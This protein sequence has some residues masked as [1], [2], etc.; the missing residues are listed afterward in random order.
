MNLF[1][2]PKIKGDFGYF[3]EEEARHCVQVLR[4]KVGESV[5]FVD[6]IG[7]YYKGRIVETGK[8][9]CVVEILQK[10]ANY[11]QRDYFLHLGIAPTKNIVRFEWLLEKA[12]E[13]GVDEITPLLCEHSE[14]RKIR[15]DRL[16]KILLAAMKQSLKAYLPQL[17]EP[18]QFQ[19]FLLSKHTEQ[20]AV[21]KYIAHCMDEPKTHLKNNFT[22]GRDVT[23]L[24]GPEGDF[25][26]EEIGLA[27]AHDFRSITLGKSRLRTETA[28][29]VACQIIN[30]LNE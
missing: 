13:I 20:K 14:R 5:H 18:I 11:G 29:V 6:G 3:S 28:G 12:T 17:N 19:Q 23:L 8:R 15:M 27:N 26:K 10:T 9:K 7:G 21:Q 24:V 25:S 16:Q 30:F 22:K 2:V 1:Y 4:T